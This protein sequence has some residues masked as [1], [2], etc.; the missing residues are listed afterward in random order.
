MKRVF[1]LL[2]FAL[3]S[4]CFAQVAFQKISFNDALSKARSEGKFVFLQFEAANCENC[5]EGANK[6]FQSN[7]LAAKMD[8]GFVCLKVDPTHPDRARIGAL[9]NLPPQKAFG[10]LFLTADGTLIHS[11]LQTAT[12]AKIYMA[13]ADAALAKAGEVVNIGELEKEYQRGNRGFG[14]LEML[15]KKRREVHLPTDSLLDEYVAVLPVDSLQSIST[16]AFIAQMAPMLGSKADRAMRVN[17]PLFNTA[18]YGMNLSQRV[19]INNNIINKGM[20]KAIGDK[21]EKLALRTAMFAQATTSNATARA[22][23]FDMNMLRYYDEVNDTANYF[24]L[25][26]PYYERFFLSVRA[27]SIKRIDSANL[28]SM[29]QAAKKDTVKEGASVKVVSQV[30]YSPLSQ[31]FSRELNNGAY[32]FY[33]RTHDT[34]LLSIATRWAEKALEFYESPEDLDTYAKLLYKQGQKEAAA[35]QMTKAI[36]LQKKHG[37]PANSYEAVLK[38]MNDNATLTD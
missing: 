2:L 37:F 20:I 6:A 11:F 18:W 3:S 4:P 33:L 25:S 29:M 30:R 38:K 13:Q 14:F 22:K 7:E 12:F 9:Y 27:D 24:R 17:Q 31:Y 36:L 23:A 10:S 26:V 28:R 15:L 34:H 35:A 5:N 16:L 1:G 8:P 21:N 32:N 19:S